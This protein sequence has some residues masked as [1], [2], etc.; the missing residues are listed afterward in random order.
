MKYCS[1]AQ[2]ASKWNL[3]ERTVRDYCA[4]GK[5][6]IVFLTRKT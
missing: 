1:V 6:G 4:K 3:S 5:I 2:I